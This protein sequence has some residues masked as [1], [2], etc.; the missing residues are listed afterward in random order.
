MIIFKL[1]GYVLDVWA[2]SKIS[3][4]ANEGSFA[5]DQLIWIFPHI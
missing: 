1:N 2:L 3:F 5:L 4:Y